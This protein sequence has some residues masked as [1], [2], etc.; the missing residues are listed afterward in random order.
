[1]PPSAR[2]FKS[3]N[4]FVSNA[5]QKLNIDGKEMSPTLWTNK[6]FAEGQ[7]AQ[8]VTLKETIAPGKYPVKVTIKLDDNSEIAGEGEVDF[9]KAAD[10]NNGCG[11][12]APPSL[13]STL[14]R[15]SDSR[16]TSAEFNGYTDRRGKTVK[17]WW[18][19][20]S[21]SQ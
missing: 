12:C 10:N 3:S 5:I 7:K 13:E 15:P 4:F 1:M 9:K 11:C 6:T 19:M 8:L 14:E 17:S 18:F 16:E 2:L 20:R 21:K